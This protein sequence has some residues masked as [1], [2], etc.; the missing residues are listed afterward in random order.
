MLNPSIADE[1]VDD[2][3]VVRCM[4]FAARGNF[5]GILLLNLYAYITAYPAQ[6]LVCGD[7]VGPQNDTHLRR[8]LTEQ[9]QRGTP[10]V[11]GWGANAERNQVAQRV[12]Q[13]LSLVPGVDWR[14]L[15]FTKNGHPRHPQRLPGDTPLVP[16]DVSAAVRSQT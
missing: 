10:V 1:Y 13:V 9:V 3:T 7:P 2:P 11:A 16:L 12:A 15:G 6:L 4:S 5:E 14:C 8:T